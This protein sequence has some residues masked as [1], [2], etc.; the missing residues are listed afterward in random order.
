MAV[1]ARI[2]LRRQRIEEALWCAG[3]ILLLAVIYSFLLGLW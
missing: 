1:P 2:A 3:G